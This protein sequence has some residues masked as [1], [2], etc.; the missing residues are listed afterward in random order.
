MESLSS[1]AT[2]HWHSATHLPA[3]ATVQQHPLLQPR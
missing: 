2:F 1:L 3:L